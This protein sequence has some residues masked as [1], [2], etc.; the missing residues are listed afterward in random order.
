ML[1]GTFASVAQIAHANTKMYVCTTRWFMYLTAKLEPEVPCIRPGSLT[2]Q[3]V[4]IV[5]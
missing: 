5:S 2:A 1:A 4:V 3:H